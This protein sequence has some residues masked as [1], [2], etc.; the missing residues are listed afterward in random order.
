LNV[1]DSNNIQTVAEMLVLSAT[2]CE[3]KK[4]SSC[5]TLGRTDG[6]TDVVDERRI[7]LYIH[8]FFLFYIQREMMMM[9]MV[10]LVM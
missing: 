4:A 7:I 10:G 1:W 5:L 9:M 8:Y 2:N 3:T 6:W